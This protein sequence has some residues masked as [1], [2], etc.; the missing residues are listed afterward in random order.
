MAITRQDG[1]VEFEGAT[2]AGPYTDGRFLCSDYGI[3]WWA[4]VWNG[5][6]PVAVSV[7]ATDVGADHVDRV[8]VDATPEVLAAVSAWET[9]QA[10]RRSLEGEAARLFDAWTTVRQGDAVVVF[11]GR[12][13]A[14]GT[15]GVV[16]WIGQGTWGV[17]VGLAVKG[18]EALVYT[19]FDNVKR[20]HS[21][22]AAAAEVDAAHES[23]IWYESNV[24][25]AQKALQA[26]GLQKGDKVTP[27][28]GA[29]AGRTCRIIWAGTRQGQARVGVVPAAKGRFDADWLPVT[30]ATGGEALTFQGLRGRTV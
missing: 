25:K 22:N 24:V 30:D 17:R 21:D 29:Y 6:A 3:G 11:K 10:E 5:S 15:L 2:L 27:K 23:A 12:K 20:D 18:S 16:R 9:D 28:S 4:R 19:A 8:T 26:T 1:K 13:V 14:K 7:G